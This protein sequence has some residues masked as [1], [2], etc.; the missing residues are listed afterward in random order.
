MCKVTPVI[1]YGVVSPDYCR[2][3]TQHASGAM[4]ASRNV[5]FLKTNVEFLKTNVAFQTPDVEF[6]ITNVGVLMMF[7]LQ[8]DVAREAPALLQLIVEAALPEL[9]GKNGPPVPSLYISW[10]TYIYINIYIF[11]H[12]YVYTYV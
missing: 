11:R 3:S 2:I 9:T 10:Y 8:G 6:L 7:F 4:D 12:V 1:L 5:E